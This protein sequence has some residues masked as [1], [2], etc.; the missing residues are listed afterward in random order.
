MDVTELNELL[1]AVKATAPDA[2]WDTDDDGNV[3][4]MTYLPLV[5]K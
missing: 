2:K 1:R 3:V 5:V 4:I